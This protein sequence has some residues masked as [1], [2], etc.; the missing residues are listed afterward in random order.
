MVCPRQ[1]KQLRDLRERERGWASTFQN[2]GRNIRRKKRQPE[3][4]A[5]NLW[6]Q[7]DCLGE[8][9]DGLIHPISKRLLPDVSANNSLDQALVRRAFRCT[10]AFD[11]G[12]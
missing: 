1:R 4:L 11:C 9:L 7:A 10:V 12:S 6:M 8:H 5:N 2:R 3:R